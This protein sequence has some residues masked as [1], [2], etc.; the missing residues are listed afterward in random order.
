[1]G[2]LSNALKNAETVTGMIEQFVAYNVMLELRDC[3]EG[4]KPL[5]P[6]ATKAKRKGSH[7]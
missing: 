3:V 1:M 4:N 7:N 6:V 2:W 5:R